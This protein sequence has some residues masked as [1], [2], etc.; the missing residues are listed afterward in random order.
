MSVTI[1]DY[2]SHADL[3]PPT[4]Y[5][6]HDQSASCET[7][8]ADVPE[9]QT[10]NLAVAEVWNCANEIEEFEELEHSRAQMKARITE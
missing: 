5:V 6:L 3:S 9:G 8:C 1:F 7:D 2:R 4:K 10:L